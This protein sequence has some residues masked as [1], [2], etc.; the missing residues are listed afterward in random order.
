[1]FI[2]APAIIRTVFRVKGLKE[3]NKALVT[4]SGWGG[5]K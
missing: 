5:D 4:V 2:A 3:E 1:M